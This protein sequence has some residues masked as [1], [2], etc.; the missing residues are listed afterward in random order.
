MRILSPASD[1]T[2]QTLHRHVPCSA[3]SDRLLVAGK[4]SSSFGKTDVPERGHASSAMA[5]G[6]GTAAWLRPSHAGRTAPMDSR[7]RHCPFGSM[8]ERAKGGSLFPGR[9]T[10]YSRAIVAEQVAVVAANFA[11]RTISYSAVLRMPN[12]FANG[13]APELHGT[14]S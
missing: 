14:A 6:D 12:I 4:N 8:P 1:A 5:M 2:D 11:A 9:R 7:D 10:E 3:V 13:T